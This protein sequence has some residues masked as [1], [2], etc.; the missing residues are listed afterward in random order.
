VKRGEV[1]WT[2]FDPAVGAEIRKTR[3]A[4]ILTAEGLLRI[5][6]AVIVVPFSTG[7]TPRPPVNVAVPSMTKSSVAVCDQARC[8]DKSRLVRR[9]GL[10]GEDDLRSVEEA[11]RDVLAL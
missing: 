5:R 4:V 3:P 9:I 7:P 6:R 1:W 11:V 8:L 2:A 10:L